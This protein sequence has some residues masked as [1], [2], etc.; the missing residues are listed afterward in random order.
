MVVGVVVVKGGSMWRPR[1]RRHGDVHIPEGRELLLC[2]TAQRA[3][4][5]YHR[6]APVPMPL[7]NGFELRHDIAIHV[8]R[9]REASDRCSNNNSCSSVTITQNGIQHAD[10]RER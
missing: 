2:L 5:Y 3:S 7:R 1:P 4:K 9:H 6:S 8:R 10:V